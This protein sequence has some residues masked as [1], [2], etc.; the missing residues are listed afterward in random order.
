MR[1]FKCSNCGNELKSAWRPARCPKCAKMGTFQQLKDDAPPAARAEPPAAGSKPPMH[2]SPPPPP[3][4]PTGEARVERQEEEQRKRREEAERVG[5]EEDKRRQREAAERRRRKE[6]EGRRREEAERKRREEERRRQ[7]EEEERLQR[8]KEERRQ[9]EEE[10]RRQRAEAKRRKR[11]EEERRRREEEERR[12]RPENLV[13]LF[14]EELPP[15]DEALPLRSAPAVDSHGRIFACIRQKLVAL[16]QEQGKV[17]LLWQYPT[18]SPAPG[19][20]VIGPDGNI[21]LHCNDGFLHCV[22]A[23]GKQAWS[24]ALVGE[25]L[26]WASP[27][28][29]QSANTYISAYDGGLIKV[30]AQGKITTPRYFRSRQKLDSPGIIRDGVLYIG[31]EDSYVWAL[32]LGPQKAK[33]LWDHVAGHGSTG[34]FI[35]SSPALTRDSVLVVASRD[36]H[37]HGFTL[38]GTR[39]WQ[40]KMPEHC[41]MLASPVIDRHGNIYVGVSQTQRGDEPRGKLISVDGNSHRIRWEC[42]AAGAVESTPVIGDDDVIYFGD[43]AGMIH[44]VD[45]QGNLQWTA[46]VGSAV[47]SAGTIP[48]PERL[49]FG[50]DNET[51]VVLKCSSQGLSAEGWPKISR[52]LEQSGMV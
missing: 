1:T 22:T 29:D 33:S 44:A 28:V 13:W 45:P 36:E 47:R 18:D 3:V 39:A 12:R 9:R 51:L 7:R 37:L 32:Q 26:G 10:E 6:E 2:Q 31:S 14:P 8:E 34:W 20:P 27:L 5:R 35:N 17:K 43:N 40:T 30:D 19:P 48:S 15:A 16:A 38:D 24:P 41:Q 49:A 21:R 46:Q 11:R 25:P 4:A 23:A 50:L 42:S 52:T